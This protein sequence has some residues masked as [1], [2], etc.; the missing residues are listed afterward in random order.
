MIFHIGVFKLTEKIVMVIK[1][2]VIIAIVH[3][4]AIIVLASMIPFI[5]KEN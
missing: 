4:K 3:L 2:K 1:G 5:N